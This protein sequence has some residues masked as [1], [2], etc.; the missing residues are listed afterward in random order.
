MSIALL[1]GASSGLGREFALRIRAR[2]PEIEEIWLVA[3]REERLEALAKEIGCGR[4][5]AAD[6]TSE[7]GLRALA[8]L[9]DA[10]KPR[11][12]L[13]IN[14]AGCGY[15]GAFDS[16]A[17]EEQERMVRLNCLALTSVTR[18]ALPYMPR[19]ARIV[20]I[21]SIASFVP[22][23]NMAV[24]SATKAYVQAFS[25]ALGVEL[26]GR[27]IAVTAVCPGPMDTE[28]LRVGRIAGHSKTFQTLPYCD[29]A[30]V[31]EGSLRAAAR[32]RSV[33]TPRAFYKFYR[34]V[35]HLLPKS[36]LMP[37]AKT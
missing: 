3:R 23:A 16:S 37:L 25:R 6:L 31:A 35:A 13:L 28:F 1:T 14:C 17:P 5:V 30:R 7:E 12:G 36:W 32:G 15:L 34:V 20:D 21:S 27:G 11:V 4:S 18:M 10:E 22:N 9:L 19:G 26:K 24:Y 29:A 8:S 2:F 33:W